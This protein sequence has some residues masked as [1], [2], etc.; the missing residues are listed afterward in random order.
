MTDVGNRITDWINIRRPS[1]FV[2]T[3]PS[4]SSKISQKV[5]QK[6]LLRLS[7]V[8]PTKSVSDSQTGVH[9]GTQSFTETSITKS[10]DGGSASLDT[11][12]VD[13][14][15]GSNTLVAGSKPLQLRFGKPGKSA[16]EFLRSAY[17]RLRQH[18]T[19]EQKQII[20]MIDKLASVVSGL[21]AWAP[22]EMKYAYGLINPSI[23]FDA[24]TGYVVSQHRG[25]TSDFLNI[26][27]PYLGTGAIGVNTRIGTQI[28]VH[29]FRISWKTIN[30]QF[31]TTNSPV[32]ARDYPY[33]VCIWRQKVHLGSGGVMV[34]ISPNIFHQPIFDGALLWDPFDTATRTGADI[35][36]DT[37]V[38]AGFSP[39]SVSKM[40]NRLYYD[41]VFHN[42]TGNGSVNAASTSPFTTW[43]Y[44]MDK[45]TAWHSYTHTFPHGGLP[46]GYIDD[47]T[48]N[49]NPI[50]NN[51]TFGVCTDHPIYA[52]SASGPVPNQQWIAIRSEIYF[53][54]S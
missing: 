39:N 37:T 10:V 51:I 16:P 31:Y 13:S 40:N 32:K 2:Q 42:N 6:P 28:R 7:S 27:S 41:K 17:E 29:S 46:V 9:S 50:T 11:K 45:V 43:Q 38:V 25:S 26:I 24:S 15:I 14:T 30:F 52:A 33:R 44:P 36:E 49:T 1:A 21:S 12:S 22:N 34:D 47:S 3:S 48:A 35:A 54:D 19:D 18:G 8:V 20:D 4:S 53:T 23:V 5:I